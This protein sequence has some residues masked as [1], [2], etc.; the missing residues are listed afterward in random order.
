MD[1]ILLSDVIKVGK[2]GEL[3]RVNDGFARNYLLP[4]KLAVPATGDVINPLSK[5]NERQANLEKS[6]VKNNYILFEQLVKNKIT[7]VQRANEAGTLFKGV[8][9]T[10]LAQ[11]IS[12]LTGQKI[13]E[14]SIILQKQIKQLS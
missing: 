5:R 13:D 4:K 1:V 6:R 2:A 7:I 11:R 9:K 10:I 12:E 3:K 8:T 14:H